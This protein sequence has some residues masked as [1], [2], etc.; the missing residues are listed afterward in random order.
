MADCTASVLIGIA[1]RSAQN[2]GYWRASSVRPGRV[3][4]QAIVDRGD[5]GDV[6]P[7][8][9]LRSAAIPADAAQV[10]VGDEP[11]FFSAQRRLRKLADP[12]SYDASDAELLG[13]ENVDA[14]AGHAGRGVPELGHV[15]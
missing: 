10:P 15:S 13:D 2:G 9:E 12:V 3:V 8:V 5:A 6:F 4:C 14:L 11:L 7:V 1:S